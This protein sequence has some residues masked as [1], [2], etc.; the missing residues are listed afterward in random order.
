MESHGLGLCCN[1]LSAN[2]IGTGIGK[3]IKAR[4]DTLQWCNI[5]GDHHLTRFAIDVFWQITADGAWGC[6]TI[7]GLHE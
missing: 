3:C 2:T 7:A 5:I 6:Q 4:V 1:L